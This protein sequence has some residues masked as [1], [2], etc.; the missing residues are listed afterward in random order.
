MSDPLLPVGDG[1]TELTE[2]DRVGLIPSHIITRGDLFAAEQRNIALALLRRPPSVRSLLD[3]GYLRNLHRDMFSEVWDWAGR[4]RLRATNIGID[5][6]QIS[7]SVRTLVDDAIAWVDHEAYEPDELAVRFHHRLVAIHPF[8][9]GNGRHSRIAADY[10]VTAL[11]H[12]RF[13][14][15]ISLD[16]NTEDL[17]AAYHQALQRADAGEIDELLAFARS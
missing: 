16:V 5:P 9:N 3:D 8:P 17:R 11:G 10:L 1:H 15:G 4:Y 14:W 13:G 12:P 6:S 2:D 7:V